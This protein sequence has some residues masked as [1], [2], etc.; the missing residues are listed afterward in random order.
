MDSGFD[1]TLGA[2]PGYTQRVNVSPT[3]DIEFLAEDA[4]PLL[5]DTPAARASTGANTPWLM[6]T[7]V[8]KSGTISPPALSV[9]PAS[10]SFSGTAGGANPA[11]KTLSVSNAGGG[12]LSWTATK[13]A[14][15]LSVSPAGGTNSG[16]ITV[17]PSISSLAAGTYTTDITA[18]ARVGGERLAEDDPGHPD[19]RSRS[20]SGP[21]R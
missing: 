9:S 14:P 1:R 12:T 6:A 2:D 10:L 16:T 20:A 18:A 3:S 4:L 8:F 7:V 13:S 5:G 17:T 19:R 21:C 15:W 11:A